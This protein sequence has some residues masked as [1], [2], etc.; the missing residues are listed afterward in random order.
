MDRL[1]KTLMMLAVLAI[2]A[3][4]H[5]TFIAPIEGLCFT[6]G[7][8]TFR[9]APTAAAPDY[10]IKIDNS[11]PRP[12]L[13]MQLVDQPELADFVIVDDFGASGSTAC[14]SSVPVKTVKVDAE[15][16]TPDVTVNL[17]AD[18]TAPD[19]RVYVHSVRFSHQDA[20]ALLAGVWKAAQ[21]RV[22]A[23]R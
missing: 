18:N 14:R 13:R 12:D 20:A 9:L 8:A 22:L 17:S 16:T 6:S 7:A 11:A 3:A 4:G 10:R 15:A 23:A 19:Y 1:P 5:S 21:A 2:P